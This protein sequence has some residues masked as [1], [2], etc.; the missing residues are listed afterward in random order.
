MTDGEFAEPT[1]ENRNVTNDVPLPNS[2]VLGFHNVGP[3]EN[4]MTHEEYIEPTDDN[5]SMGEEDPLAMSDYFLFL[6]DPAEDGMTD[7]EF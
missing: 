4:G 7:E 2:D 3:T 5:H 1:E 6:G